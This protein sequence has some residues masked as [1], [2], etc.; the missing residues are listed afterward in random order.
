MTMFKIML[1]DGRIAT[2]G[3]PTI[4]EAIENMLKLDGIGIIGLVD[5]SVPIRELFIRGMDLVLTVNN[6][7]PNKV[8]PELQQLGKVNFIAIHS[9]YVHADMSFKVDGDQV[10]KAQELISQGWKWATKS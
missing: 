7:D 2:F 8:I 6:E 5:E 1:K 10:R 3:V 4:E 9:G